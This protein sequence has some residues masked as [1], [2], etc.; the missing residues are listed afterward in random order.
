[1]S[2]IPVPHRETYPKQGKRSRIREDGVTEL[3]FEIDSS[4]SVNWGTCVLERGSSQCLDSTVGCGRHW[5]LW[6]SELR[7][8]EGKWREA[9]IQ[10]P[11]SRVASGFPSGMQTGIIG[12]SYQVLGKHMILFVHLSLVRATVHSRWRKV[13]IQWLLV[14]YHN[15][16]FLTN[17]TH[18]GEGMQLSRI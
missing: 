8:V 3:R 9:G 18:S 11:G 15:A 2:C 7:R 17:G 10:V 5:N 12:C 16:H 14:V 4:E 6:G 1:M 13:D